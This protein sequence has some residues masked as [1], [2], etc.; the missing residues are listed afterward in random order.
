[1]DLVAEI[2]GKITHVGVMHFGERRIEVIF[3]FGV[4]LVAGEAVFHRGRLSWILHVTGFTVVSGKGMDVAERQPHILMA[5]P[6]F[7]EDHVC[8]VRVAFRKHGIISVAFSAFSWIRT[9]HKFSLGG[10]F[11][12][13]GKEKNKQGNP[14]KDGCFW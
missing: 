14:K 3:R 5:I 11:A 8:G 4:I 9:L 1:M 12:V 2:T 6:A 10:S 13:P 7:P